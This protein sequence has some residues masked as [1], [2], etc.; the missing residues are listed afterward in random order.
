MV[1]YIFTILLLFSFATL[2][3][4]L[5]TN[6]PS[7]KTHSIAAFIENKGQIIDQNNKLNPFVL[8]LLNMP[9]MNVQLRKDGFSYDL[10]QGRHAAQVTRDNNFS[11]YALHVTH[12]DS[13]IHYPLSIIN[14]HRIDITLEGTNPDCQIVPSDSLPEYFN[15]FTTSAPTEGIKNVRQYSKITYKNIYPDIDLDFFTT[16]EHGYE[17]NFVIHPGANINDIQLKIEGPEL[18]SLIRDTLK[19]GTRFGD[20]EELIPESYYLVND[21]RVDV[22][23]RFTRVSNEVYGFAVNKSI[24]ENSLLV[25][26]PTAIRLWGTYYGG[27]EDETDGQCSADKAG[28]VFLAGTTESLNNIASSGSYQDTLTGTTDGFLAKFNAAGQR[29]W[30]TYFGGGSEELFSCIVDKSGNIYVAGDTHSTSG[31]ASPGAHQTVYG[32]GQYDCY[33]EKFRLPVTGYG[34]LIMEE[35]KLIILGMLLPIKMGMYFLRERP[36]QIQVFLPLDPINRIYITLPASMHFLQ[37][38]I[39]TVSGNGVLIMVENMMTMVQPV[40]L[41]I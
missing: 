29:Q 8:F 37:N 2:C 34:E 1:K 27:T 14:Y 20:V 22:Q 23:A 28:N 18:I 12:H 24:P 21:S 26:D 13:I 16:G 40:R 7:Y 38:L 4:S 9:G 33:I 31:I 32:G 6:N 25:I 17:Y 41:M 5:P 3:Q 19:F 15:Y 11:R 10:Y 35:Q 39:A 30:G 36:L